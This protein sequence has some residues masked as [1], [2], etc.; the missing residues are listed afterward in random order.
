MRL[1]AVLLVSLGVTLFAVMD[2]IAKVLAR[3]HS[4]VQIIWARYV[5]AVPVVL[6]VVRP[7]DWSGLLRSGRPLL[8]AG[9]AMLPLLSSGTV[10]LGVSLMPLADVTAISFAA[11]LLVV[12]LSAPLLKERIALANWVGVACGFAGVLIIVRPG[13]GALAW[14]AVFPLATAFMFALYQVL[15]RQ[16]RADAPTVTLAWTIAVGLFLSTAVLPLGWRS[17]GAQGWTLLAVSGGLFGMGHLLVIRGFSTAPA[18]VLAPFSYVQIVAA[19]GFGI[20]VFG[21]VPDLWTL[22][23]AGLVVGAGLYEIRREAVSKGGSRKAAGVAQSSNSSLLTGR[24][25]YGRS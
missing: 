23:G 18:A 13:V 22:L 24:P 1:K 4:V 21:D 9:R 16:V 2:G 25:A 15:T 8:Q 10:V 17:A 6:L 20:C 5:F 12:T 19:I 3:D 11:P 14:P 7:S